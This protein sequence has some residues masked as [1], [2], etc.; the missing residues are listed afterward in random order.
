MGQVQC[1]GKKTGKGRRCAKSAAGS[2]RQWQVVA[3]SEKM[4]KVR[5]LREERAKAKNHNGCVEYAMHMPLPLPPVYEPK[6]HVK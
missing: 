5:L 1:A 2:S 4:Q 3:G 6:R